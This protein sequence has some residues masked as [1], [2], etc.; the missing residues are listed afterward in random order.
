MGPWQA[1]QGHTVAVNTV[2][3]VAGEKLGVLRG[4]VEARGLLKRS[5]ERGAECTDRRRDFLTFLEAS[6]YPFYVGPPRRPVPF[7]GSETMRARGV[8]KVACLLAVVGIA[9]ACA[10]NAP[11]GREGN[12]GH[13]LFAY[14]CINSQGEDPACADG[15]DTM[16]GFLFA[17]TDAPLI[18]CRPMALIS[19][20]NT[21]TSGT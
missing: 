12:L 21:I 14:Q 18:R 15:T 8:V 7:H 1:C 16:P 3:G 11:P 4:N 17:P 19:S 2:G 10:S 5:L 9:G 13:G 20:R 6:P